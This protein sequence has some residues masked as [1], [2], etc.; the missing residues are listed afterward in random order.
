MKV[1]KI[2]ILM[3]D[4][5][6]ERPVGDVGNSETFS[7]PITYD[8]IKKASI[9]RVLKDADPNIITPFIEAAKIMESQ[10]IQ[11]I[12]T[13]CGFL[14]LFQKDIQKT[15]SIPFFS[16]SLIQIPMVRLITGGKVGVLTARKAS[17]TNKHLYGVNVDPSFVV[18]AGMDDM[19]VFTS[20]IIEE[21]ATLDMEQIS[22]EVIQVVNNLVKNNPDI[23]SIVLECTNLPPYKKAIRQVTNLPIF[24][25]NSLT[26]YVYHSL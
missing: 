25:I 16:S 18:I 21:T 5:S 22:L 1:N 17:L 4:T 12:T 15:L 9:E 8:V 7:F 2:G 10:G 19:P 14:A 13:S 11:G 26:N 3:L 24:D 6:F 23:K 20:A